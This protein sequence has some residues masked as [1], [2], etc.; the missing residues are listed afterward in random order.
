M[1]YDMCQ[2]DCMFTGATPSALPFCETAPPLVMPFFSALPIAGAPFRYTST[3]NCPSDNSRPLGQFDARSYPCRTL[4]CELSVLGRADGSAKW[5]QG[6]T[7]VLAA[8]Y[9]PRSAPP[10]REMADRAVVEVVFKPRSGLQG[11]CGVQ[12]TGTSCEDHVGSQAGRSLS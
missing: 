3:P 4:V 10:R 7:V 9:G 1:S 11:A 12:A 8:V 6:Q 5:S 2:C